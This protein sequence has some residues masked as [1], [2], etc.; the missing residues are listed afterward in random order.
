MDDRRVLHCLER[1]IPLVIDDLYH[2]QRLV[3]D[4]MDDADFRRELSPYLMMVGCAISVL[5]DM[6]EVVKRHH[7]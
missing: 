7:S 5:S 2:I 3:E 6:L 4:E 1:D